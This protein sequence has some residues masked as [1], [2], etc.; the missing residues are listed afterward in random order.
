MP[1]ATRVTDIGSGHESFIPSATIEGSQNVITC[2][3]KQARQ[4]DAIAAHP[5]PS[6]SPPHSRNYAR[7]SKTVY[8]NSREM[9]RIADPINCGGMAIEGCG[10]VIVGG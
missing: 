4:Y 3:L 6:P 2:S 8:V 9:I 1:P 7:G 5:S 10:T